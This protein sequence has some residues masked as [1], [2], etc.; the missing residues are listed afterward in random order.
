MSTMKGTKGVVKA[1]EISK[2]CRANCKPGK[3]YYIRF[4]PQNEDFITADDSHQITEYLLED[5]WTI[6]YVP[7]TDSRIHYNVDLFRPANPNQVGEKDKTGSMEISTHPMGYFVKVS[8][9]V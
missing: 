6:S 2:L 9:K 5:G 7:Y 1:S 8:G 4:I 3:T